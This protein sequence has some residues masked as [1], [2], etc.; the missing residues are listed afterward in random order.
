[1]KIFIK[2]LVLFIICIMP[3]ST[4]AEDEDIELRDYQGIELP[5]GTL[6]PVIS[7]QSFST[8]THDVGSKLAFICSSDLFLNEINII[9]KNTKFYGYISKINEPIIGTHAAIRV[10]IVKAEFTDGYEIPLKGYIYSPNANLIGGGI[11]E[12]AEYIQ[13]LSKRQGFAKSVGYVPGATRKM[14]EHISFA[15]GVNLM[16]VLDSPIYITHTVTN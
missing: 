15:S 4:L 16:I 6:I 2:L 8:L 1:M 14:G 10:K 3:C 9:P 13:K 7:L 12:P 5:R 11:T